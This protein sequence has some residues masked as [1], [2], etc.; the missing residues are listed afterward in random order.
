MDHCDETTTTTITT[1][2]V[3]AFPE[4]TTAMTAATIFVP[5][6]TS[7]HRY[8]PIRK[9]GVV[10]CVTGEPYPEDVELTSDI[11]ECCEKNECTIPMDHCDQT[12]T[13]TTMAAIP[14]ETTAM[15]S[16][17][18]PVIPH[19][20]TTTTVATPFIPEHYYYRMSAGDVVIC[21][22]AK[23][24]PDNVEKYMDICECCEKQ[25]CT[26]NMDHCKLQR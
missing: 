18:M 5:P 25:K 13:T 17:T 10:I 26:I 2:T 16:A 4:E 14:D 12:T 11:C 15:T 22:T 9:G 21:V 6:T 8:Y 23:P 1:T 20:E 24:Y 19:D 7:T 3:A